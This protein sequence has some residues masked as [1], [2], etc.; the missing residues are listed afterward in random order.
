VLSDV[1]C[2]SIVSTI[3]ALRIGSIRI[4]FGYLGWLRMILKSVGITLC[5]GI[6]KLDMGDLVF[7]LFLPIVV[8]I[9]NPFDLIQIQ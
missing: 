5:E 6:W 9:T 7:F 8:L 2:I 3:G 1:D 4:L